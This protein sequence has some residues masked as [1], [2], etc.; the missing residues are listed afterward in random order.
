VHVRLLRVWV[1]ILLFCLFV[2]QVELFLSV[3]VGLTLGHA[4]YSLDELPTTSTDP[5]CAGQ[6]DRALSVDPTA[7]VA[8]GY[9]RTAAYLPLGEDLCQVD[10][11]YQHAP[12]LGHAEEQQSLS[13]G[14]PS[15][16]PT[17]TSIASANKR[18]PSTSA[19]AIASAPP[20]AS[21]R[22]ASST[23]ALPVE[24]TL[25]I[26]G[27]TCNACVSTVSSALHKVP[28]VVAAEV[29]LH[30]RGLAW[31]TAS[32]AAA[33]GEGGFSGKKGGCAA[34]VG[35]LVAVVNA[36]GFDAQPEGVKDAPAGAQLL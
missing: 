16:L 8:K 35:S 15:A 27:M 3:V 30:P 25:A 11:R 10:R 26:Q 21:E 24:V 22:T 29:A 28:G 34:L 7:G 32:A 33:G 9:S 23:G 36:C 18:V 20:D 5:C 13:G 12:P 19:V 31:V 17:A 4:V 6:R 14:F 1:L 2:F